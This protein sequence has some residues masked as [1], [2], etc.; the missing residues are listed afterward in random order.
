MGSVCLMYEVGDGGV[1][2]VFRVVC[3]SV[4][5]ESFTK[6]VESISICRQC[7]QGGE[8]GLQSP[9]GSW[10]CFSLWPITRMSL[11]LLRFYEQH[12]WTLCVLWL[13]MQHVY[14]FLLREHKCVVC[15]VFLFFFLLIKLSKT[16]SITYTF[17]S[18]ER[19]LSPSPLL[20]SQKGKIHRI[21]EHIYHPIYKMFCNHL[22]PHFTG[23]V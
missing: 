6:N 22:W 2:N 13:C 3:S 10:Q 15:A 16:D 1:K 9:C 11:S 14:L 20:E 5:C 4:L 7:I 18:L 23:T 17:L 8:D 12:K 21:S 19:I